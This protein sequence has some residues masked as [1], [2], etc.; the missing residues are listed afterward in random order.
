[1]TPAHVCGAGWSGGGDS[2]NP[3]DD[4]APGAWDKV[5]TQALR[6]GLPDRPTHVAL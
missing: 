2:Q 6:V 5:Y 1:M 4:D 3:S